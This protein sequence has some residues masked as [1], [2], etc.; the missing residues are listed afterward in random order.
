MDLND[1]RWAELRGGYGE[2]YDPRPALARLAAK[3]E[4]PTV[5]DELWNELHHQG[6]IGDASYAAIIVLADVFTSERTADWKL[7]SLAATI[8]IERH[9]KKNPPIPEW[10]VDDYAR[11]WQQ[12]AVVAIASLQSDSDPE[13]VKSALTIIALEKKALKLGAFLN[14]LDY[15][16]LDAI[17]DERLMWH[18]L[19][20]AAVE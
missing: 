17:V 9:R 20:S 7:F 1:H 6:N 13:T 16:E 12:L 3:V 18:D 11:A 10:L 15:S 5:W 2:L 19:Y 14:W 4:V 8:E